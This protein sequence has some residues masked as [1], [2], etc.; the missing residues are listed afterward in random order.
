LKLEQGDVLWS[1]LVNEKQLTTL[2]ALLSKER[3]EE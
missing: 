2:I 3:L 1:C